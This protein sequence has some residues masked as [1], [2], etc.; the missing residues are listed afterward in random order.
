MLASELSSLGK[1]IMWT[2]TLREEKVSR[3]ISKDSFGGV[4]SLCRGTSR[5][6]YG[7]LRHIL[8]VLSLRYG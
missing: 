6:F 4:E 7:K 2:R 1:E 3:Q 8:I 5:C